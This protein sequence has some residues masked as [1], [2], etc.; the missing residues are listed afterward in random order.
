MEEQSKEANDHSEFGHL[1][2]DLIVAF[3]KKDDD[4]LLA[5]IEH[6]TCKYWGVCSE[7]RSDN[8]SDEQSVQIENRHHSLLRKLPAYCT[9]DEIFEEESDRNKFK[10]RLISNSCVNIP[11]T[12]EFFPF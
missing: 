5:M 11:L 8:D 6:K 9:P 3:R 10:G 12:S 4:A 7:P 2:A 1:K